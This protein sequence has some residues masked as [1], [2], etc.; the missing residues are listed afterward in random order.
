MASTVFPAESTAST[1]LTQKVQV[2]T[3]TGTFT[4][5]SNTTAVRVFLVAGGGGGGSA[6]VSTGA[7][8]GGSCFGGGGGGG[9]VFQGDLLVT[10]GGSYTVTIGAA[11]AGG[12]TV[13]NATVGSNTTFGSLAT[14]VGGGAGAGAM[15]RNPSGNYNNTNLYFANINGGTG[16]G[17]GWG[18][19]STASIPGSAP[20]GGGSLTSAFT[21]YNGYGSSG[22]PILTGRGSMGGNGGVG[23]DTSSNATHIAGAGVNGYGGGGGGGWQ[24][25]GLS[26]GSDSWTSKNYS[27][28]ATAGGNMSV[29]TTTAVAGSAGTAN[30]GNGG[31]G[32]AS[33]RD[34]ATSTARTASG[35]N[36]GTGYAIVTYWT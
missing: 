4:V 22:Y 6:S 5:P 20:S 24:G 16:G 21:Y 31:G 28:G 34:D 27:F 19:G 36:G 14:A 11:G 32:A 1:P 2:F 29:G 17:Q 23:Y 12:L 33:Y 9:S 10:A 7:S 26:P 3:S 18:S 25:P 15:V 13:A 8:V 35:G 30:S